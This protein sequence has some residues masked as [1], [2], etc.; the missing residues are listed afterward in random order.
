MKIFADKCPNFPIFIVFS[1]YGEYRSID[2]NVKIKEPYFL[3]TNTEGNPLT[4]TR[5][6]RVYQ[7]PDLNLSFNT[8]EE[9]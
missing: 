7:L 5:S 8:R 3:H 9:T 6:M 2:I 1:K 4:T